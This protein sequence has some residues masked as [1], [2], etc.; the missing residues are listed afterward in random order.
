MNFVRE[1]S[2]TAAGIVA[3]LVSSLVIAGWLFHIPLLTSVSPDFISMKFN[4]AICFLFM[5]IAMVMIGGKGAGSACTGCLVGVLLISS[6]TLLEYLFTI[7]I[8]I[9]EFF[10]TEGPGT[11]Y[12]I[13]PGRPSA[14]TAISFI[15]ITFVL[16]NVRSKKIFILTRMALAIPFLISCF[17]CISY[18]FGNPALIS[19]PSLSVIAL[20]SAILFIIICLG[21]YHTDYFHLTGRSLQ[22]RMLAGF[23]VIAFVVMAIAYLDYNTHTVIKRSTAGITNHTRTMQLADN[24]MVTVARMESDAVGNSIK[25]N[26]ALPEL[27]VEGPTAIETNLAQLKTLVAE[28]RQQLRRVD[29]LAA[30]LNSYRKLLDSIKSLPVSLQRAGA[31]QQNIILRLTQEMSNIVTLL[32][33]F[34]KTEIDSAAQN[35]AEIDNSKAE[36]DKVIRFLGFSGVAIFLLLIQFIFKNTNARIVAEAEARNLA[37]TLEKKVIERTDQLNTVN[38]QLHRLTGHLQ[39]VQEDERRQLAREVNDEIGQLASAAKM[40]IDWVALHISDPDPKVGKR[41]SN[42]SKILQTMIDDVRKIASSLRPVM[43]DELG[44]NDSI[45]WLC[46][47]FAKTNGIPCIFSEEMDDKEIPEQT[48]TELFRICQESLNTVTKHAQAKEITVRLSKIHSNIE[49]SVSDKGN[50]FDTVHDS[51]QLGLI[52][53]RERVLA[54]NGSLHI[55]TGHTEGTT[56]LVTV[57]LT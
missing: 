57:P 5:G 41:I 19:I 32:H 10:W 20:H 50:G 46:E 55:N 12:T 27:L 51:D 49:L 7:N 3:I 23:L 15:L 30:F 11:P 40:D 39:Q 44:L 48:R 45:R 9:D 16:F 28:D 6:L 1:N 25:R 53:I 42:A 35:Q 24:M 31:A 52:G 18:F 26:R 13:Y 14:L 29:S 54:I 22:Q 56:L 43:I 17:S 2:L 37:A 33:G 34:K 47:E 4:T 38:R 36:S 21:I 8:G